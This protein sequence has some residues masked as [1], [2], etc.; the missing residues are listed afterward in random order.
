MAQG[1]AGD[2]GTLLA[3]AAHGYAYCWSSTWLRINF[4]LGRPCT[5]HPALVEIAKERVAT[6]LFG[7]S[8]RRVACF[9]TGS[10]ARWT[11]MSA[12]SGRTRPSAG[13]RS[14]PT[15]LA[16]DGFRP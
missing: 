1:A 6:R 7:S 2:G 10:K 14:A 3:E 9:N 5:F 11:G 8:P 15:I 13:L 12:S 4:P 16:R